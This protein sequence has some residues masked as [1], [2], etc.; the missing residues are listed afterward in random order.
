MTRYTRDQGKRMT[1]E[2]L[3]TEALKQGYKLYK[4]PNWQCS[5]H[6]PYPNK[7]HQRK[8]GKW[9]CI[10]KY[11]PVQFTQTNIYNPCT[12]CKLKSREERDYK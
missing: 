7:A 10:D 9:K 6:V 2:E 12:H 5:C 11:E 3:K 1:F 8:N 4:I